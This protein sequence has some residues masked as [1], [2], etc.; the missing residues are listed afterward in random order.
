[1]I[2]LPYGAGPQ[3]RSAIVGT[4]ATSKGPIQ[5]VSVHLQHKDDDATRVSEVKALLAGL[6]PVPSRVVAGDFN[7]TPGSRAV[8]LMLAAG[9]TSAQDAV[10]HEQDT[11]VG[12]DFNA[13]IDYQFLLGVSASNFQIGNSGRSDHLNLASTVAVS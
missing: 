5:F 11:Y 9:Y 10:W 13:R 8:A 12:S 1:M 7:D 6:K 4:I 3:G 2:R